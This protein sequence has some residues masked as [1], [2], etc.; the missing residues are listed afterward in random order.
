VRRGPVSRRCRTRLIAG[1]FILKHMHSLADEVLCAR[2]VENPL[3][4][5]LEGKL[6]LHPMAPLLNMTKE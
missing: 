1:L 6:F 4:Q 2:W 3:Y 5:V